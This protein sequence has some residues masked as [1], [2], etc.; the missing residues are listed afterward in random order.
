MWVLANPLDHLRTQPV[1]IAGLLHRFR[2]LHGE[3]KVERHLITDKVIELP[4]INYARVNAQP[5][6]YVFCAGNTVPGNFLDN[7]TK[8]DVTDRITG[9]DLSNN[10]S[11]AGS[12]TKNNITVL[13]IEPYDLI[14][15][16]DHFCEL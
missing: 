10:T 14:A 9:T 3:K 4:R 11:L 13:Q 15:F 8:V 16:H 5:Y 6:R 7:L 1:E 2:I 12:I